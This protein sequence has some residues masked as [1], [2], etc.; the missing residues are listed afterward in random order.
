[1]YVNNKARFLILKISTIITVFSLLLTACG[2]SS[3]SVPVVVR[4]P[5]AQKVEESEESSIQVTE[6]PERPSFLTSDFLLVPTPVAAPVAPGSE[7]YR[8]FEGP[9]VEEII[10]RMN[11][12]GYV[13]CPEEVVIEMDEGISYVCPGVG[14]D[15]STTM[16]VFV[17][18]GTI[19]IMDGPELGPTDG[20]AVIYVLVSGAVVLGTGY[21]ISQMPRVL[22][23]RN[24]NTLPE[25]DTTGV[26]NL[27]PHLEDSNH[28]AGAFGLKLKALG[29][30]TV[31]Q[32]W[33][34]AM[35]GGPDP[36]F[37][38]QRADGALLVVFYNAAIKTLTGRTYQGFGVIVNQGGDHDSTVLMKLRRPDPGSD[39]DSGNSSTNDFEAFT[40][41]DNCPPPPGAV[42]R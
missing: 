31:F 32:M 42:A 37:C 12:Q 20:A 28:R 5:E 27:P 6:T 33:Q 14:A 23:A 38:G 34:Q 11:S 8:S 2:G 22:M 41:L 36:D 40:Q 13:E 17:P 21:A 10:N 24:P 39:P 18:A 35:N 29:W 7:I 19:A 26:A 9:T 1:M 30:V 16:A 25:V 3:T 4:P 15:M